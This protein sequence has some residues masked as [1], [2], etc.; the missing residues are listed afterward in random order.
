[1][2]RRAE[3]P[4]AAPVAHHGLSPAQRPCSPPPGGP[5]GLSERAQPPRL[6]PEP[7]APR[8]VGRQPVRGLGWRQG[9]GR[10]AADLL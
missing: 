2:A 7:G 6:F 3:P 8:C 1:M 10:A 5:A 4:R 9:A